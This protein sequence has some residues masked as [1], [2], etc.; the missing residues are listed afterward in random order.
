M[1]TTIYKALN[2]VTCNL[3]MQQSNEANSAA[4]D[5]QQQVQQL[6]VALNF[7]LFLLFI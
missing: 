3:A 7:L 6:S 2:I 1:T 5:V 4:C